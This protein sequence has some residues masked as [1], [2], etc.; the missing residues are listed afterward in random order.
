MAMCER[1]LTCTFDWAVEAIHEGIMNRSVSISYEDGMYYEL[2]GVRCAVKVYER[3]SYMGSNR[4]SM[5]V[6]VFG[7]DGD[8]RV[9]GI[10]S[11]GSQAVFFKLNTLG[12]ESFLETLEDTLDSLC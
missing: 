9:C 10:T 1:R 11:G 6:T 5:T 12:E 3:Y 8:L 7:R 2:D 4:V